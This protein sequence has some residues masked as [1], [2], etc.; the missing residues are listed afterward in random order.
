MCN[1]ENVSSREFVMKKKNEIISLSHSGLYK[2]STQ[3]QKAQALQ[4]A[5]PWNRS[6][7]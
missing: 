7:P 1:G 2:F 4:T 6:F 3:K 5:L